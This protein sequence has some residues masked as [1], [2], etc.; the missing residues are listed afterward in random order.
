MQAKL[1]AREAQQVVNQVMLT[2]G[3]EQSQQMATVFDGITRHNPEGDEARALIRDIEARR[4]SRA[5]TRKNA[6]PATESTV[7]PVTT[8]TVAAG[9]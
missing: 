1:V 7:H 3:L 9:M 6:K 2:M 8:L 5:V 4:P